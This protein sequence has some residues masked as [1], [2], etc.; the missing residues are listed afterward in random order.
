MWSSHKSLVFIFVVVIVCF[1]FD[2]VLRKL[3]HCFYLIF[4]SLM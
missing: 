1:A 4:C 2:Y 3:D